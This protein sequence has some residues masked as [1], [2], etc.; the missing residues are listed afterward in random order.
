MH[1]SKMVVNFVF[2][3]LISFFHMVMDEASVKRADFARFKTTIERLGPVFQD[4]LK[5]F[6]HVAQQ[7]F[8]GKRELLLSEKDE[9]YLQDALSKNCS[10]VVAF[11]GCSNSGKSSLL[12]IVLGKK[13]SVVPVKQQCCTA[14]V[15]RLRHS[16]ASPCSRDD[17]SWCLLDKNGNRV[18]D[19]RPFKNKIPRELIDLEGHQRDGDEV[20]QVVEVT[21]HA[22]DGILSY[23]VE[24]VDTPGLGE[25]N[26]LN[27]LLQKAMNNDISPLIVY[28]IDGQKFL[29]STVSGVYP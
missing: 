3:R 21:V 25:S 27:N 26:A 28:V 10:P 19:P 17:Q 14:R 11:V 15:V 8:K 5:H 6:D 1:Y 16:S 22:D 13:H 18:S 24:M 9:K 23:G 4:V 12:N 7:H 2:L 20:E 29:T